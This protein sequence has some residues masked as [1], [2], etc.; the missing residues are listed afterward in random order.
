VLGALVL[1]VTYVGGEL[2]QTAVGLP[3]AATGMFQAM[4][5][6]FLLAADVLVRHRV[7]L[8]RPGLARA[9]A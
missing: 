7:R 5:L 3:Q 9:A 6:F 2:A 4:L 1:A 8:G